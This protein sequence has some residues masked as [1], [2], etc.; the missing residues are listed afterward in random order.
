[1]GMC[2]EPACALRQFISGALD[3]DCHAR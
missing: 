2:T 3:L 1:M